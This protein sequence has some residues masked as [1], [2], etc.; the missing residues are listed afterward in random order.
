MKFL[1][2]LKILNRKE[3]AQISI[4]YILLFAAI[5]TISITYFNVLNSVYKKN[6]VI[7][8]NKYLQQISKDIQ[9]DIDLLEIQ[10]N[11]RKKIY[12]KNIDEWTIE[13]KDNYS[14]YIKNNESK[15]L[16]TSN[17]KI[18]I[19][20]KQN[21]NKNNILILYKKENIINITKKEN[22]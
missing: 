6:S 17:C 12:F 8:D 1:M 2:K 21:I 3:N 15:K 16:I 13:K 22:I 20:Q 11:S 10:P 18:N 7:I 9:E 19:K 14:F 4:E 5:I